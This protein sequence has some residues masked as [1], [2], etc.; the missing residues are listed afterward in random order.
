MADIILAELAPTGILRAGINLS[1]FLLVSGR[2]PNGDPQGVAPDL[3]WEIA[4]RLCVPISY[5]SYPRPSELADAAGTGAWD[6]GLI[7]AEPVRAEKIAFTA[8]YAE[9]E[10]TYLLPAG[11]KL[12][13]FADVDQPGVRISVCGGSAYD[14]WLTRNIVH[15]ELVRSHSID[16]SFKRFVDDGLD[17]LA[18]LRPRLL[19]DQETL[20]GS[21]ILNGNFATVQQAVGTGRANSAG[22]AFLSTFVEEAKRS[23]LVAQLIERHA[24]RGLSVAKA[25]S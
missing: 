2:S 23:G 15:A 16:E 1:N 7:G 6:I 10:T 21:T 20:P 3:A 8:A 24:V 19:A 13:G 4:K 9:I 18:G 25:Q 22:A 5:V 12:A 14:L 17:A 11:S